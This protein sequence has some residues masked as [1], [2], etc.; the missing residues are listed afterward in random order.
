M[1]MF[2]F[3]NTHLCGTKVQS[4]IYICM[5]IYMFVHIYYVSGNVQ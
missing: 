5:Y 4:N 3:R 2:E 1:N